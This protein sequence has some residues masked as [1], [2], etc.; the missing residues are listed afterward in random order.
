MLYTFVV[1]MKGKVVSQQVFGK[2]NCIIS[3]VYAIYFVVTELFNT[4]IL[5][6]GYL[7]VYNK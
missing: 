2:L 6:S 3:T 1:Y 4:L 5:K 7:W